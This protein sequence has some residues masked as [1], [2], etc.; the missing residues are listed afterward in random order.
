MATNEP[1]NKAVSERDFIGDLLVLL[2]KDRYPLEHFTLIPLSGIYSGEYTPALVN[3]SDECVFIN[4]NKG[5]KSRGTAMKRLGD[6]WSIAERM[7][8]IFCTEEYKI[9]A[10]EDHDSAWINAF[11]QAKS[12]K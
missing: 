4:D 1:R 5:Y 9:A 2:S 3:Y 11:N 10:N 12:V 6:L 8:E 7:G